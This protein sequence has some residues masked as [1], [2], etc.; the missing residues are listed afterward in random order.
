[1]GPVEPVELVRWARFDEA[2][3]SPAERRFGSLAFVAEQSRASADLIETGDYLVLAC[4]EEF[5]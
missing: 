5:G 4:G 1:L 3:R 2:H